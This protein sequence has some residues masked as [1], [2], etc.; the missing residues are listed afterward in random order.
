MAKKLLFPDDVRDQLRRRYERHHRAWLVSGGEWPLG[1]I[2]GVP[3]ERD[4]VGHAEHVREWISAWSAWTGGVVRWSEVQWPRLGTQTLPARL[5]LASAE[6]V[7]SLIGQG[8]RFTGARERHDELVRRWPMLA[9][10]PIIERQFDMLA[11]Y[12]KVEYERLLGLLSWLV[13]HP[14]SNHPLRELP[15]EGIDTKWIEKSRRSLVAEL[16][17]AI[18]GTPLGGDFYDICGLRRP[19]HRVRLM[20]LCPQMRKVTGGLRDLETPL[21]E[22]QRLSLAPSRALIV[23][24]LESGLSL[25]DIPGAVAFVK[26]GASVAVLG[27][28]PWLRGI[29]CLYWGDID[30]YGLAILNHAR[31]ALSA[32]ESVLMDEPTLLAHRSLWG[33][34]S[35][36]HPDTELAS[37]TAS[38]LALFRD[39]RANRWGQNIRLEQERIPWSYAIAALLRGCMDAELPTGP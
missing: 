39:L 23:E 1:I 26:L 38:E 19:H 15:V 17:Q 7:A 37:L 4:V 13:E 21:P 35:Q 34:E 16:L 30:T 14:S 32:V 31:G 3:S 24:N 12:P 9:A 27:S 22:L 33:S 8:P 28:V 11:D 5:E 6:A 25:P 2:L 10:S 36:S 20:V 29:A 18:R